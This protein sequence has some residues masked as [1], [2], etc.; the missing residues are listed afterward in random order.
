MDQI[1]L[2][3]EGMT[4]PHCSA[5]V[6]KVVESVPGTS[7]V[8]VFLDKKRVDFQME[9]DDLVGEV[10]KNINAAGYTVLD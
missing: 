3:V 10:K 9:S 2:R 4:C 1:S 8:I 5:T 7:D 6:Q